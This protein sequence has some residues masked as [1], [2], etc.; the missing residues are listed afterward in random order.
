MARWIFLRHGE[1][2]ANA[3]GFLAGWDDVPLTPR[4]EQQ[5]AEAGRLLVGER[6]DRV[7]T[8]DLSRAR[9]TAEIAL[10]AWVGAGNPGE[11]DPGGAPQ[12]RLTPPLTPDRALRERNLGDWSGQTLAALRADGRSQLLLGWETRPPGGE[13]HADL[14]RRALA[15]LK[16]WDDD[17]PTLFVG[18]GGL[19]RALLGLLDERPVDV[20][21]TLAVPNAVPQWRELPPG[22][23]ARLSERVGVLRG[24]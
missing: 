19:F 22:T 23:W 2:T 8:S 21:G 14:A 16:A 13:S 6:F 4:G 12:T 24:S 15:A 3:G 11:V 10:A 17:L 1:S 18:H 7:I 5:A 9:R 20:I